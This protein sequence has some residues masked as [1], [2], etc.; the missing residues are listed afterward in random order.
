VLRAVQLYTH[1]NDNLLL[2]CSFCFLFFAM[3]L[4]YIRDWTQW[5]NR[6]LLSHSCNVQNDGQYFLLYFSLFNKYPYCLV[7]TPNQQSLY[8]ASS[9]HHFIIACVININVRSVQGWPS[10]KKRPVSPSLLQ[11]CMYKSDELYWEFFMLN[12][13]FRFLWI[14]FSFL[15]AKHFSPSSGVIVNSFSSNIQSYVGPI[16]AGGEI[17]RH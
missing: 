5:F 9:T 14:I 2:L 10:C 4:L 11:K 8:F 1:E 17:I 6:Y 7:H 15:P 12:C 16:V 3:I 13:A